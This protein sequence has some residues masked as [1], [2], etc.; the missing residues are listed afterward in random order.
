[1]SALLVDIESDFL[2]GKE[3]IKRIFLEA[4]YQMKKKYHQTHR[5]EDNE[6]LEGIQNC[7]VLDNLIFVFV[8]DHINKLKVKYLKV[9][10]C[11]YFVSEEL[12]G[13]LKKL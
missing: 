12:K 13:V 9:L 3:K 4:Y 6:M 10:I 7:T 5:S 1:M 11:F 8:M 2:V